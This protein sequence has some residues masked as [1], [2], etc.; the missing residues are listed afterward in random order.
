MQS[1]VAFS[2]LTITVSDGTFTSSINVR[3]IVGTNKNEVR[4][5]SAPPPWAPI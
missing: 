1:G 5:T 2:D 3:V 4:S